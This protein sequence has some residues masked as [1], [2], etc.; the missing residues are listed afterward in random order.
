MLKQKDKQIN[1]SKSH[2][3]QHYQS[4]VSQKNQTNHFDSFNYSNNSSTKDNGYSKKKTSFL[5]TSFT[6]NYQ[7]GINYFQVYTQLHQDILAFS[8]E[9]EAYTKK[10]EVLFRRLINDIKRIISK[11]HPKVEVRAYGSH[12]SGLAMPWSDIDLVLVNKNTSTD[13]PFSSDDKHLM[14]NIETLLKENKDIVKE[15]KFIKSATVP[16]IKLT[17]TEEF[18]NR[19]VDLTLRE[20]TDN[21]H[22]GENCVELVKGYIK[23]YPVFKPLAL[24]LKQLIYEAKMNDTYQ[25]GLSSY[26]I[27]LMVVAYLQYKQF[28]NV[29]INIQEPNLGILFIDLFNFYSSF[30][31]S[32]LEMK[33]LKN[34]EVPKEA[35]ITTK[36]NGIPTLIII[37]PLDPTN[38]VAKGTYNVTYLENLLYFVYFS[39]FHKGES[40]LGTVFE[41]AKIYANLV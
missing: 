10:T 31:I 5:N 25:G 15:I 30:R 18:L 17:S 39:A 12:E 26:G 8:A 11:R 38:N 35:T 13:N 32:N 14:M 20:Y 3:Q 33:P 4:F 27:T 6:E 21:Q 29:S 34:N 37:D 1:T 16:V 41:A 9:H 22:S 24:V 36:T 19:K 7:S 23:T 40:V 2:K 28:Y